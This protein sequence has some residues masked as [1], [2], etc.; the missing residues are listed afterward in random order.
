LDFFFEFL[1]SCDSTE[2]Y[3]SALPFLI[4]RKQTLSVQLFGPPMIENNPIQTARAGLSDVKRKILDKLVRGGLESRLRSQT[5]I[6]RRPDPGPVPLS[7]AQE[8]VWLHA[9]MAGQAPIYNEPITIVRRGEC[10][11]RVL[12]RC[13][14]EMI[15]RHEIWRTTFD[16]V[17]GKP[18]QI[19]HPRSAGFHLAE[20]DLRHVPMYSREAE[21]QRLAE[22]DARRTFDIKNGPLLRAILLRVQDQECRICMTFHQLVFDSVTAYRVIIPELASLYEAFS[23]A[24]RSTLPELPIQYA[25]FAIWQRRTLPSSAKDEAINYWKKQLA[26]ELSVLPWPNDRPRPP[27]ESHR[28]ALDHFRF[29]GSLASRIKSFSREEGV[30]LYVT[31]LAGFATVLHRYTGQTDI[32]LGALSA[33]RKLPEI[34]ALAGYFVNPL[35][36]RIGLSGDPNFRELV[37][38]VSNV[39]INAISRDTIPFHEL[40]KLIQP[41][42]DP[43]R[44]PLFQII[45]SLQPE[46]PQAYVGWD[47]RTEEV[48]NG[49]SKLDL[50]VVTDNR[51]DGIFGPITYNP[52]LFDASTISRMLQHWQTILAGALA[53]PLRSIS[54]LPLLTDS[55]RNQILIEWNDTEAA[56]PPNICVDQLIEEQCGN[57]PD[58]TAIVSGR[59]QLTYREL[60][61]RSNQFAC[62][63]RKQGVGSGDLVGVCMDRSADLVVAMLGILKAGAAYV[64]VD[65]DLP[66]ERLNFIAKD[67]GLKLIATTEGLR[68]G[69]EGLIGKLVCLDSDSEWTRG[70]AQDMVPRSRPHPGDP[71]Y[72]IY[73]SGSTGRPKGVCV[74]HRALANFLL[75]MKARPGLSSKD[76]LLAVTTIS[77]DISGLELYLPLVCG[78]RCILA[79]RDTAVEG[80]RLIE[81]MNHSEATVMQATPA[82]WRLLLES[83]WQGRKGLKALCGGEAMPRELAQKLLPMVASLWNMYGPTETTIWSAV[84]QITPDQEIITLG[85]PIANTQMYVLDKHLQPLPIGSMGDLYIGGDGLALGYHNRPDLTAEKFVANPFRNE[86]DARIYKTGDIA[87]FRPNGEIEYL[88]R[89]DDQVKIRGFRIEL[90]EIETVIREHSSVSDVRVIV[91]ENRVGDRRLVAYVVPADESVFLLPRILEHVRRKLP[92]YMIP[93]FVKLN[94]LPLSASGKLDRAA[95]PR[96]S[97]RPPR[98][99]AS[100]AEPQNQVERI[101]TRLWKDIL[102]LEHVSPYD[103]FIDVGGHSLLAVQL[104]SRLQAELGVRITPREVAFQTLRQLATVCGE[105]LPH[106]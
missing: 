72:I 24:R 20:C 18:V 102:G 47:L 25:D 105:Q 54:D 41:Q 52:D 45:F 75:S 77:F 30:S 2:R 43:S 65:P 82:T 48:G 66:A 46:M 31:L 78:G 76:V 27:A 6:L 106:Q 39:V 79:S 21:A 40:V 22:A 29:P 12:E 5:V 4:S 42:T 70:L 37:S 97:Q 69:F 89:S 87:R 88:G 94:R 68:I 64:P 16:T 13:L 91:R 61:G 50:I 71:A 15:Q 34:E 95:L 81:L 58:K 62:Y 32:V 49:S 23:N 92:G 57:T 19:I 33:G 84:Q 8:Q 59:Q 1:H 60:S 55:E 101:L 35:P 28:G 51:S 103:N 83:G 36:L 7:Y 86:A 44:N 96:P 10:D 17:D 63:L 98:T 11:V 67:A 53:D 104:V 14:E 3:S 73:T 56:R 9:Q 93:E 80:R 38:R 99:D 74:P 85:R 100:A 26:G 90:G